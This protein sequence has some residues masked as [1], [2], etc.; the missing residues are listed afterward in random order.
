MPVV[1]RGGTV[2]IDPAAPPL[3]DG[4]VVLEGETIAAVGSSGEVAVPANAE[5][6]DCGGLSVAAGFWNS[7]VHF[8]ERKWA[9][10][11]S[12][13]AA[14]LARQLE[15]MSTRYGFTTVFDLSSMWS[16]TRA[17]RDRIERGPRI[18]STGEGLVRAGAL[19]SEQVLNVMGVM[20]TPLPEVSDAAE[21][22]AAVARL[23]DAGVDG[24]K[25]FALSEEMTRA[26][27][28]S[29][30]RPVFVHP[31]TGEDVL[32]ALRAGADVIAHTTPRSGAW[33]DEI[34]AIVR[35]RSPALTPTLTLW[36][37][38]LR[39]DRLSVQ[40]QIVRAAIDQLRA[41]IAAGGVVLF[42]TDLGAVDPDP[43]E[44]Y[45]LMREAG[46]RFEDILASL[47]S[48]PAARFGMAER[49]GR[50]APG[51]DADLAVF[52]GSDLRDVRV[53]IRAGR[54]AYRRA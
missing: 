23:L 29:A 5:V 20:K 16:N 45:A 4:V 47:T 50:V 34:L 17:L 9:A 27:V 54:V 12:I 41:W 39:H 10:A 33:T 2:W 8:F 26:A 13:P 30:K 18:L 36:R 3:R 28:Q 24:I 46:M 1:L 44:E 53:T 7:H 21:T 22:A 6:I 48:T 52:A 42:G 31:N 40:E 11:E 49:S 51:F 38:Y 25:L 14:E 15:A 37:Y 35:D 32:A 43:A 19:P